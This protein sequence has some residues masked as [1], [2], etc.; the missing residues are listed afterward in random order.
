MEKTNT[1]GTYRV[2]DS[3]ELFY[4]LENAA[5][6]SCNIPLEKTEIYRMLYFSVEL[7]QLDNFKYK[8]SGSLKDIIFNTDIILNADMKYH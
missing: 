2:D 8:F 4:I 3:E 7:F 5:E 1:S 6:I